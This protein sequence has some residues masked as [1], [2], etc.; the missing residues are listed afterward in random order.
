MTPRFKNHPHLRGVTRTP[1]QFTAEC[2]PR[3]NFYAIFPELPEGLK[4][5]PHLGE[6]SGML[7]L[8]YTRMHTVQGVWLP[9]QESPERGQLR[10]QLLLVISIKSDVAIPPHVL[11]PQDAVV[12]PAT[13]EVR[14]AVPDFFALDQPCDIP[15]CE[16]LRLLYKA[17]VAKMG[18]TC[19]GC[20]AAALRRKYSDAYRNLL[21]TSR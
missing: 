5:N 9:S 11:K 2:E 14:A 18:S 21:T 1:V 6:I 3:P 4:W 19:S 15:G 17:D 16:Q 12:T 13:P 8:P 10:A 20:A 7:F